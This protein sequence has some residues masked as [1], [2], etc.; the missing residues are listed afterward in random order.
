[1]KK[2]FIID[3]T[4]IPLFLAALISGIMLHA[5][6][7][8]GNHD[9]WHFRA[10]SHTISG[11][12]FSIALSIH[13]ST[14]WPWYRGWFRKGLG[15][16]SRVTALLSLLFIFLILTGI[17]LLPIKGD[18]SRIGHCHYVC[19]IIAAIIA[20]GHIIKRIPLLKKSLSTKK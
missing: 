6:A 9:I 12:L 7:S 11:L 4:L 16:K 10:L 13:I 14:H 5:A 17:I 15:K 1:M 3:W 8:L 19:G 18:N 2:I 20:C